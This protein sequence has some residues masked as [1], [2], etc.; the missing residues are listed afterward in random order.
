MQYKSRK[1]VLQPLQ[2]AYMPQ[3]HSLA[4]Q[5]SRHLSMLQVLA[6]ANDEHVTRDV[7][8]IRF[9]AGE[10]FSHL[11][12]V[13]ADKM[14]LPP[15][16]QLRVLSQPPKWPKRLP[17]TNFKIWTIPAIEG[18][19]ADGADSAPSRAESP[20]VG[21]GAGSRPLSGLSK[22]GTAEGTSP[23]PRSKNTPRGKSAT[24]AAAT[25]RPPS[26]PPQPVLP[27]EDAAK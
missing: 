2:S 22:L 5:P 9:A 1:Q 20:D 27:E 7:I 17:L 13:P 24:A 26:A 16:Y 6:E 23:S 10:V 15:P 11:P 25:S 8:G 12:P 3:P 4:S 18:T 19:T 14:L 21:S